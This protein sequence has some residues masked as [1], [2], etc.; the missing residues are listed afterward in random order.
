MEIEQLTTAHKTIGAKQTAKAIARGE[1]EM[2]FVANNSDDRVVLPLIEL[3][4]AEGVPI[5]QE[6]S[7]E[8]LGKAGK[9][10]VKA[11]AIGVLR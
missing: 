11:A 10:K 2:V 9:I 5:N 3:C 7:M 4:E 8:E 1:V 6:H